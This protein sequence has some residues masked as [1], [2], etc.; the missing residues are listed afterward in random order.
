MGKSLT[1]LNKEESVY[2]DFGQ[3]LNY[4]AI[5]FLTLILSFA[6]LALAPTKI[7]VLKDL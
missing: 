5:E 6:I 3:S 1:S 7:S 4:F 2:F